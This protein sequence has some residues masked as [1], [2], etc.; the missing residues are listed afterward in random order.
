MIGAIQGTIEEIT[1]RQVSGWAMMVGDPRQIEVVVWVDDREVARVTT[2]RLAPGVRESGRHPTGIIVWI[3]AMPDDV[4]IS[5]ESV[6]RARAVGAAR[7]LALSAP[8]RATRRQ[9]QRQAA[10]VV[11]EIDVKLPHLPVAPPR[12]SLRIMRDTLAALFI[13]EVRN[14][15]GSMRYGYFWAIAQPLLYIL[16]IN[17]V[18]YLVGGVRADIYGVS[19]AYFFMIGVLP[20]F[21]FQHAYSQAMGAMGGNKSMFNYREIRPFDVILV[22]CTLEFL[23]LFSVALMLMFG[24]HWFDLN[25][26][27]EDPL[28]FLGVLGL[29]YLFSVGFGLLA[30]VLIVLDEEMRRIISLV[31][32]P[33]FFI[34]GVFFTVEVVPEPVRGW[35]MWNPLLH[36]IDLGRG[37]MLREYDS[38]CSFLY[39]SMWAL[40]L[41]LFGLA[42]YQRQLHRLTS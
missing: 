23:L 13:R 33:L 8:L 4:T 29:L 35:L 9:A 3:A 42:C 19:G 12:S 1:P 16:L 25:Y 10:L 2:D 11:P 14:R 26:Q 38:P 30:D 6:V 27:V 34:S 15:F 5:P 18:R 41:L 40:G 17:E 37:A 36:A 32:R 28:S 20:F 39:L 21:M 22:R 24:M 7:D 31:E